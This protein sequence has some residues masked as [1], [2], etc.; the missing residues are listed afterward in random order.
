MNATNQA[1]LED[2]HAQHQL[3]IEDLLL[4]LLRSAVIAE[5]ATFRLSEVQAAQLLK[6]RL[7]ESVG[8]VA[9]R[10]AAA[11]YRRAQGAPLDLQ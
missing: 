3:A 8:D 5:A 11:L 2:A 7:G 6:P 1:E 9:D 10:A 4:A